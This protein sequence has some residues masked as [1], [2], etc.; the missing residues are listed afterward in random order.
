MRARTPA[1]C[2]RWCAGEG[3]LEGKRL[4]RV[5]ADR[6]DPEA[7]DVALESGAAPPPRSARARAVH[8][9]AALPPFGAHQRPKAHAGIPLLPRFDVR[10]LQDKALVGGCLLRAVDRAGGRDEGLR[11]CPCYLG[12]ILAREPVRRRV[13]MRPGVLAARDVAPVPGRAALVEVREISSMRNRD[14]EGANCGGSWMIGVAGRSVCARSTTRILPSEIAAAKPA[15][16]SLSMVIP[17]R[18]RSAKGVT[19]P[20]ACQGGHARVGQV[21]SSEAASPDGFLRQARNPRTCVRNSAGR[22][23]CG[24][25]PAPAITTC[26]ALGNRRAISG[27]CSGCLERERPPAMSRVGPR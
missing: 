25:W 8:R 18:C 2:I 7:E 15:S 5:R 10:W 17:P 19:R 23:A 9:P 4:P 26:S 6:L 11:S 20:G 13:E 27:R 3:G 12:V 21:T 22:S 1:P 24:Q 14:E 16:R